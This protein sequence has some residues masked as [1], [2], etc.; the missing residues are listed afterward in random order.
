M[1]VAEMLGKIRAA[2]CG[3]GRCRN[4]D[5]SLRL[6]FEIWAPRDDTAPMIL[7]QNYIRERPSEKQ[8]QNL[9][10]RENDDHLR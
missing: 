3:A 4:G 6:W 8:R 9:T 1:R 5:S 2:G 7:T 10:T